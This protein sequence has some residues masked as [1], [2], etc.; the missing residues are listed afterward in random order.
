[1]IRFPVAAAVAALAA[2]T[3]AQKP[4]PKTAPVPVHGQGC[5]ADGVQS[6]CLVV[7]DQGSGTLYNLLI[8]G[9]RP[10]VG[11]GIEFTGV[12]HEGPTMCSQ[13]VPVNVSSWSR[14]DSVKCENDESPAPGKSSAKN[15][16][17]DGL[18]ATRGAAAK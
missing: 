17:G 13:G 5:V 2:F 7:R 15:G 18:S 10:K 6:G 14:S 12:P 11:D 1:M 16:S 8:S 9:S 4:A 3:F